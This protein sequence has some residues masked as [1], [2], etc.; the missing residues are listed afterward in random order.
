VVV[1]PQEDGG[2][3]E[4]YRNNSNSNPFKNVSQHL[5]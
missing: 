1:N 2:T 5:I 4:K 3:D